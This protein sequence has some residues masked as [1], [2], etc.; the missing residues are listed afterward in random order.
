MVLTRTGKK[1]TDRMRP[2]PMIGPVSST[3][4][5]MPMTTF[6]PRRHD[7][8]DDRV[9]K[10]PRERRLGEELAKVLQ[11][12]ELAVEQRP[13]RQAV[14]EGDDRRHDEQH[15]EDQSGGQHEPVG[16]CASCQRLGRRLDRSRAAPWRF[17]FRA[18]VPATALALTVGTGRLVL[19]R[20]DASLTCR[21]G[22]ST[23]VVTSPRARAAA[24]AS[25]RPRRRARRRPWR[26]G[27]RNRPPP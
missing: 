6:E 21:L 5:A 11:T 4:N 18:G 17:A 1:T 22:A 13:T 25:P 26:R 23:G 16:V 15:R 14:V 8:K 10:S 24:L 7:S 19:D 20:Q 9:P 3:A 2:R 12:D 27:C